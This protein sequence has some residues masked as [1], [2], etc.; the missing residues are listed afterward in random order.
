M[1]DFSESINCLECTNSSKCFQQ[2]IPSELEFIN[3]HKTHIHYRK[4]EII[5]KQG[6]FASYVSHI[7]DGLVKVYLEN[8]GN[9]NIN[10]RISKTSEFIGL[11]AVFGD[12]TYNYSAQALTDSSVCLIDKG[13]FKKLLHDNGN[14]SSEVIKSYCEREKQIFMKIRG[15]THKQ[16]HG[17]LADVLLY[18]SEDNFNDDDIFSYLSRKDIAD[19]AAISTESIV[20]ILT[21]LKKEK[22]IEMKGKKVEIL[23]KDLL[24]EISRRG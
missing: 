19:F 11:S 17:R 4:G 24:K 13:S 6:A 21:E 23:K 14:F 5:C 12:N 3:L 22:I 10:I 2:L 15:L 9:K 7:S 8:P 18:L 16:M 20:R 1:D